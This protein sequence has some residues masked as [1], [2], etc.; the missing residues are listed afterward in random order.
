MERCPRNAQNQVNSGQFDLDVAPANGLGSL[1]NVRAS[2][3]AAADVRGCLTVRI[4]GAQSCQIW[5]A[6]WWRGVAMRT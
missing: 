5:N 2:N 4:L 6:R 1:K 3:L